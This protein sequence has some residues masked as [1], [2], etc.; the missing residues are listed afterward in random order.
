[1]T[2]NAGIVLEEYLTEIQQL[3][4]EIRKW[5]ADTP[6][7]INEEEMEINEEASGA[8]KA[9]KLLIQDQEKREIAELRPV[10]A[11]IIG[12][13]GAIDIIGQVDKESLVY[14][15]KGGAEISSS[16]SAGKEILESRS[17]P[18]FKGI[19]RD[20]W[21]WIEDKRRG[22]AHLIDAEIFKDLISEVSDYEF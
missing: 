1:M 8:Y 5:F 9:I 14:M 13:K 12:A 6:L 4:L 20:G 16:I 7:L 18:L 11:W 15:K 17:R 22:R 3:Y 21:Y 10:G 2:P 19:D